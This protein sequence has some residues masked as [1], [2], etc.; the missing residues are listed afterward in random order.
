MLRLCRS[1]V[2]DRQAIANC[3]A[4]NSE[5]LSPAC[6]EVIAVDE[7]EELPDGLI[8]SDEVLDDAVNAPLSGASLI[9][10]K[11]LYCEFT[12]LVD[13]EILIR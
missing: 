9:F 7:F 8:P 1:F 4:A 10:I 13:R 11:F 5:R 3:L 2:P 6:R 12:E